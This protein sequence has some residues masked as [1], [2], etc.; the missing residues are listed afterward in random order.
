M[1]DSGS[2]ARQ[3]GRSGRKRIAAGLYPAIQGAIQ[4]LAELQRVEP[5]N[6]IWWLMSLRN[7][8]DHSDLIA[9]DAALAH[10]AS[11][12]YYDD[13]SAE[14]LKAQLALYQSHPLPEEY[15]AAVARLDRGWRLNGEFTN[16]TAPYY[17]NH[18]PWA[19]IGIR[20][21]FYMDVESG[22]NELFVLCVQRP[23]RST[24]RKDACVNAG[25]LLAARARRVAVRDTASMRARSTI[26]STT[27]SGV[28]VLSNGW[29]CNSMKSCTP[30]M[31]T[32]T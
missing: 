10:L 24:A 15:F 4:A 13:H 27:M 25:R 1:D 26:L 9:A 14:L 18:Y 12:K 17:E 23:D 20:N 21:L 11:S 7:A 29:V 30:P 19:E 8:V 6:A 22:M 31:L 3:C 5:G 2:N 32:P 28:L 16:D